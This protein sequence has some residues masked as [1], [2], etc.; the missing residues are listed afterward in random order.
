MGNQS[1]PAIKIGGREMGGGYIFY[2]QDNG[3]GI[4]PQYHELIF[5]PFHRLKE[6]EA[7][8]TGIGLSVVQKIVNLCE[9][10][11]WLESKKGEGTTFF[12]RLPLTAPLQK[13][14][15]A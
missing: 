15:A 14:P 9:G 5:T 7:G 10:K 11:I 8:G 3:I 4:D 12:I 6:V 13:A 2:V 1:R